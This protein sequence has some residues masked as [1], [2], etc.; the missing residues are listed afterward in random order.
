[1]KSSAVAIL[2]IVI[3]LSFL[4]IL[5]VKPYPERKN[6][7][8]EE[9][10]GFNQ[11]THAAGYG[12]NAARVDSQITLS[13]PQK[14]ADKVY[15]YL[16]DT[17][18]DH[19]DLMKQRFPDLNITGEN[20][21]D[22]SEF[23]DEY[24]DT[25][26]LDLDKSQNS[27]RYRSRINTTNAED[28]KSGRELVQVKATPMGQFDLR[29]E[30]KFKVETNVL[31]QKNATRDD[32]A[33]LL[34]LVDKAER[35]D[36]KKALETIG[37]NPYNLHHIFTIRQKRS[38]VYIDL[39]QQNFLSFSVDQGEASKLL[40]T[41]KFF[42]VDIGLVEDVYTPANQKERDIMWAIRDFM[43]EDLKNKFPE[44]KETAISKYSIVLDQI[45]NKIPYFDLLVKYNLI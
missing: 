16:R 9:T 35:G 5:G 40:A 1:M 45:R 28:P 8:V 13:I 25:S 37:L 34:K 36:F 43:V 20:K 3:T 17:Y 15:Q 26:N 22:V 12:I 21:M 39:S 24:Y 2:L 41:G 7:L 44:L 32:M 10:F 4:Y 29:T 33:P 27:A 6:V 31:S 23:T 11:N 18:I 42:S 30:L 38:R 14:Q 19:M